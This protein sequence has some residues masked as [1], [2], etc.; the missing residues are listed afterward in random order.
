MRIIL[1]IF[2]LFLILSCQQKPSEPIALSSAAMNDFASDVKNTPSVTIEVKNIPDSISEPITISYTTV[3]LGK[4]FQI[5]NA[6]DLKSDGVLKLN[7]GEIYPYQQIWLNIGDFYYGSIYA[8]PDLRVTLD[9]SKAG[10]EELSFYGDAIQFDGEG[11]DLNTIMNKHIV[12]TQQNNNTGKDK[13]TR[14]TYYEP[15]AYSYSEYITQFDSL[16]R[17]FAKLDET[18]ISKNPKASEYAW[19]I[20][21]ERESEFLQFLLARSDKEEIPVELWDEIINHNVYTVS[22]SGTSFYSSLSSYLVG[23]NKIKT[24][25]GMIS[26]LK[27]RLQELPQQQADLIVLQTDLRTPK[28]N[29][30]FQDNL[31]DK[32]KTP[33]ILSKFEKQ[34]EETHQKLAMINQSLNN[35]KASNGNL[36]F[37]TPVMKTDFGA[38]LYKVSDVEA[39]EVLSSMRERFKNK[40]LMLDFWATWCGP[41]IKDFPSSKK[42]HA[43]V[44]DEP[45]EFIYLCSSNGATEEEWKQRIAE[46]QLDGTHLYVDEK[47]EAELMTMFDSRGG[48]PT[49]AFINKSGAY[50]PGAVSRMAALD[51]EQF[52]NLIHGK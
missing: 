9:L 15:G 22:S 46:F 42:I 11:G 17:V 35:A 37:A 44:K 12:Y 40:A 20:D 13:L 23:T 31:I 52:V 8:T 38:D 41:C 3:N 39:S 6:E 7:L 19:F 29:A 50:K 21:N 14:I 30:W 33:W 36:S 18:F 2:S 49:Y 4:N 5:K 43:E 25:E 34:V 10:K 24:N 27:K 48:F 16:K 32:V 26:N 28:G 51:R 45:V 47:I 1:P